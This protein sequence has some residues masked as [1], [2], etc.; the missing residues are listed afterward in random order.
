MVQEKTFDWEN[1]S[2]TKVIGYHWEHPRPRQVVVLVHGFGEHMGRYR[3][4]AAFFNDQFQSALLG[5]DRVGHGRSGGKR[6]HVQHFELFYDEIEHL[7]QQAKAMYPGLPLLLYGHSMGGMLVLKYG[8]QRPLYQT[9]AVVSSAPWIQLAF[10]PPAWQMRLGKMMKGVWPG[11]QQATNLDPSGLST[12]PEVAK[13]YEADPLV[14]GQISV[15]TGVGMFEEGMALEEYNQGMPLPTLIMHGTSDPV[16]SIDAS[17]S[18]AAHNPDIVFQTWP[19]MRHE[20]H[21]EP[22]FKEVLIF[23]QNWFD[24]VKTGPFGPA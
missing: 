6:G 18:F 19:G 1:A 23:A 4:V 11:L 21:N 17:Q 12:D 7:L 3:H 10:D 13:A 15:T 22:A 16:T 14:H 20:I 9:T 8:L 2:G 5:N 24:K